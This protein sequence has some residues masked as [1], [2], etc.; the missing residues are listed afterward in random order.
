MTAFNAVRF[1]VKPGRDQEFLDAH[2]KVP[3]DWPGL[4]HINLIKTG[5]RAYCIIGEWTDMEALAAALF[6]ALLL[7]L[8]LS[9]PDP[10]GSKRVR[11]VARVSSYTLAAVSGVMACLALGPIWHVFGELWLVCRDQCCIPIP[12]PS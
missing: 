10:L 4:K 11:A 9:V 1:R 5:D 8:T 7:D 12:C 6:A 2:N 3:R